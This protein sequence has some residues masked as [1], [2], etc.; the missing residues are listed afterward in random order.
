MNQA[1]APIKAIIKNIHDQ[2]IKHGEN[3]VG[4]DYIKG[5]NIAVF[6][7]RR[8]DACIWRDTM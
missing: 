5:A 7:D 6:E 1:D 3:Q 2:C 8:H 4:V